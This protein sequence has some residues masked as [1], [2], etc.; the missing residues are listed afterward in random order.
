MALDDAYA[1]SSDLDEDYYL[2][3]Q[4]E[5]A[6]E[7]DVLHVLED[8]HTE[9]CR[10]SESSVI[11]KESLLAAQREDLRK[12]MDLLGVNEHNARTLLMHYRWDVER[13]FELLDQKGRD[14]LFSEAGVTLYKNMKSLTGTVTCMIC[15]EEVLP[16]ASTEMDCGHRF[17]NDCW[18]GHFIV[19]INEGLSRRIKCMAPKCNTICDES[20]IRALVSVDRPDLAEKFE[21][22]LLESYIEDNNTVKWCPSVPNCGNAIRVKGDAIC[23]VECT[24][25]MQFCFACLQEAHSPCSCVMW[26]LW[27]KK[28][29][30]ESETVNWIT[31]NTKPCPKCHKP[32]DKNGGCNLVVCICGQAFCWLC[33]GPTGREHTWSSINGHS[34]GRFTEDQTK[35]TESARKNLFRYM[36]YHNRYKA[37]IDSMKQ[38]ST[39]KETIQAKIAAS[40]NKDTSKIKDYSWVTNGLVRLFRSRRVLSYSYPFAYYMFGDELFKDEM[41]PM[42]RELKQNL[43]E[44]QQQQLEFNIEKLSGDLETNFQDLSDEKIIE[45]MGRVINYSAIVDGLCKKMYQCIENELLY[46]LR[47]THSI[48]PYKSRGL[49][50]AAELS[51]RWE[52]SDKSMHFSKDSQTESCLHSDSNLHAPGS[53]S[54]GKRPVHQGLSSSDDSGCSSHKRERLAVGSDTTA[55]AAHPFD[56]NVSPT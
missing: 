41:T 39:L 14:R 8:D 48:S 13:I 4:E 30:D 24:C 45:T 26:E 19:K 16:D 29:R 9:E 50:K 44:E 55:A 21:R 37:H 20:V 34:C 54:L 32:V 51:I 22:F 2:S 3:D 43:F 46:P 27:M 53:S 28:C 17:C 47:S 42:E 40:E 33:G 18:T 23:E 12:V 49:E 35:R 11:T 38:E 25:G 1:S 15:F 31:V 10:W 52:S 7:E 5:D 6:V 56:L 36:H